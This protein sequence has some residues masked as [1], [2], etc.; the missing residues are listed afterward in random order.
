MDQKLVFRVLISFDCRFFPSLKTTFAE[1]CLESFTKTPNPWPWNKTYLLR[2]ISEDSDKQNT[3]VVFMC[4][5]NEQIIG[6]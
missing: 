2:V 3:S 5:I 4:Y 1:E 6:S